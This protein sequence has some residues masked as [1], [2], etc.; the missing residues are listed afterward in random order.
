MDLSC[1][2]VRCP[3]SVNCHLLSV[4]R[5]P[6]PVIPHPLS[7]VHHPSSVGCHPLSHIRC[8]SS[9]VR[10]LSPVILCP[11]S[12]IRRLSSVIHHTS[13][14]IRLF[15]EAIIPGN[16][17]EREREWKKKNLICN[18]IFDLKSFGPIYSQLHCPPL[19]IIPPLL[20]AVRTT[21]NNKMISFTIMVT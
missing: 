16:S 1:F 6:S 20:V 13:S 12:V 18:K 7:V 3:S 14:V 19:L 2:V 15:A 21:I 4:I 10:L 9:V 5:R 8:P 11:S 17:W